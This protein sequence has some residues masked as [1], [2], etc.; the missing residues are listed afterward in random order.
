MYKDYK[1][2]MN[3]VI[4]AIQSFKRKI[5]AIEFGEEFCRD[6]DG[7]PLDFDIY[8]L[9]SYSSKEDTRL[10]RK[11]RREDLKTV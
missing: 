3:G 2:V 8:E 9:P 10:L 5:D 4:V 6:K 7:N 1:F 11:Q